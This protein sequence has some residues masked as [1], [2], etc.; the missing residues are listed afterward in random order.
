MDDVSYRRNV[1]VVK[2]E[3]V[4]DF[5]EKRQTL[6]KMSCWAIPNCYKYRRRM[7]TL[8]MGQKTTVEF[9]QS[10]SIALANLNCL[11]A[12]PVYLICK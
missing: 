7:C 11:S 3:T 5:A 1:P 8:E 4:I 9:L 2:L 12:P 10:A 6:T